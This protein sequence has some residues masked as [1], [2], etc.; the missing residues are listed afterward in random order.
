[1][2]YFYS[3]FMSKFFLWIKSCLKY[4]KVTDDDKEEMVKKEGGLKSNILQVE[5]TAGGRGRGKGEKCLKDD[6]MDRKKE[7]TVE[8]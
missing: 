7:F 4:V 8:R 2:F 6:G 5:W 1:M 3:Y